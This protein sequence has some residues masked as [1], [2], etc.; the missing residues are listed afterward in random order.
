MVW[1]G[2]HFRGK[3]NLIVIRQNMNAQRYC[4]DILRPVVIPFMNRHNGFVFQQGNARPH[5][6]RLTENVLQTNNVNTLPLPSRSPDLA[7][8]EHVWDIV[9]RRNRRNHDPFNSVREL[10]NA[11]VQE[12]NAIPLRAIQ[13]IIRGM[14]KR[15]RTV[16]NANGGWTRYWQLGFID[17]LVMCHL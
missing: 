14:H 8:I 10:E 9:N 17:E 3:T 7:P 15:C 13:K 5:T 4:D 2:I 12:W 11:L 1:G 6:A 16:V